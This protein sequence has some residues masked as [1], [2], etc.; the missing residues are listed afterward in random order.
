[1]HSLDRNFKCEICPDKFKRCWHLTR[2]NQ[3]MHVDK[4]VAAI[5]ESS[6]ASLGSMSS[7]VSDVYS[8]GE[9]AM[10]QEY[11]GT[12]SASS[13]DNNMQNNNYVS[14]IVSG[15]QIPVDASC[16]QNESGNHLGE[17]IELFSIII[18]KMFS[19]NFFVPFFRSQTI[20]SRPKQ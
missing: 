15:N 3:M 5:P 9:P 7:M 12:S 19:N 10:K 8:N 1:M 4:N 14:N 17:F 11:S 16:Y 6:N 13:W 18:I 2:H 20:S